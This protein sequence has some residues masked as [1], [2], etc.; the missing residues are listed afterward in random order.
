MKGIIITIIVTLAAFLPLLAAGEARD[1]TKTEARERI[2]RHE[3]AVIERGKVERE[4]TGT[5]LGWWRVTRKTTKPAAVGSGRYLAVKTNIAAWATTAVNAAVEVQVAPRVTIDVP[6]AWCPWHAGS[7]RAARFLLLQPE[8]RYWIDRPGNG[9]F[10]GLHAHAGWF[11]VKWKRDRY[12]D[13]RPLLGAGVS[14][15]YALPLGGR[16]GAEFS[17]GGGYA[18]LKYDTYYNIPN[19][20]RLDTRSRGYW[21]ITRLGINLVYKFNT[22]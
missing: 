13:T 20:A 14:L 1:T 2:E 19:G 6:L 10:A 17:L 15:G 16:W 12:Q 3:R 4:A 18:S 11:N 9:L 22:K 8:A 7:E 21:G 5:L